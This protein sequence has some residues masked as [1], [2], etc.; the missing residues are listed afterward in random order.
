MWFAK[1]IFPSI[2]KKYP[3]MK[4]YVVGSNPPKSVTELAS[5]NIIVT[6]FISDEELT[7]MYRKCKIVVVPLRYGA[8]VKGKV[9]EAAYNLLPIVTTSI[10]AEGLSLEEGALT[11]AD[12][13]AEIINKVC[14][15]YDNDEKLSEISANCKR[16]I[17]NHFTEKTARDIVLQDIT[18]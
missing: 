5:E 10:G 4:W 16:F 2:L 15:L 13:E 1:E 11:V 18:L 12:T 8:G 17:Q 6:G 7:E 9:V 3:D 14:E